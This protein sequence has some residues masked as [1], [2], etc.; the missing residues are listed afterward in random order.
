LGILVSMFWAIKNPDATSPTLA[1][2]SIGGEATV[3]RIATACSGPAR[4]RLL[5]LGLTP[6][7]RIRAELRSP[8]GDP[9]GYKVR[10]TVIAL[11][12]EQAG[13]ILIQT[14]EADGPVGSD[15]STPAQTA[16]E[17]GR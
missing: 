5:D 1:D 11:R 10:G 2:L 3:L 16:R 14:D 8:G 4:R 17:E 9:T 12:R 6:G 15:P 13:Q 7:A